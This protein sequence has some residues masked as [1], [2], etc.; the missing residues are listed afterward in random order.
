MTRRA[1]LIA[2]QIIDDA[3]AR[4]PHR[5][6]LWEFEDRLSAYFDEACEQVAKLREASR[7]LWALWD[8]VRLSDCPGHSPTI[9]EAMGRIDDLIARREARPAKGCPIEAHAADCDCDGAGG[10]R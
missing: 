4:Y 10:D 8:A 6:P 7:L 2:H 3:T 5:L 9:R 1:Q